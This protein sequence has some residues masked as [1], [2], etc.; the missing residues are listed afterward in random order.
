MNASSTT[1]QGLFE[2][3]VK[4]P[5]P[6]FL[7]TAERGAGMSGRSGPQSRLDARQVAHV[8]I[9]N[10]RQNTDLRLGVEGFVEVELDD[11]CR[12]GRGAPLATAR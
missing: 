7:V 2:H 11:A 6:L 1:I 5:N 8:L 9:E 3:L 10:D 12:R 4:M